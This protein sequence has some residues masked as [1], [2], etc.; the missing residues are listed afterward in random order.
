VAREIGA[1]VRSDFDLTPARDCYSAWIDAYASRAR[2]R[3]L[4]SATISH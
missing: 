4:P 1:C 2:N 3:S